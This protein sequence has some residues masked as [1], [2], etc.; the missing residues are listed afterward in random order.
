M[1]R[2][3]T[4]PFAKF[5]G[6]ANDFVVVL[7]RDVPQ[8]HGELARAI[9][10]R[11]T[12]VGADGLLVLTPPKGRKTP[13]RL[14][15]FNVDGSEAEMSG[16]GIRC[17]GAYL[18]EH[19]MAQSPVRLKTVAGR[20]TLRLVESGEGKWS[21]RVA[22]GRPILTPRRIPFQGA[23]GRGPIVG[24]PLSTHRGRIPVT[25]TSIGN[26]HCSLFVGDF[27]GIDWAR[28][29]REI[30]NDPLFPRRTN[31]EFVKV[32][33]P[34]EI[35]VRFWERGVGMTMSSG[36]GS[37]AAVVASIL[38]RRTA[39]KVRVRTLG[40]TL[41]IAWPTAGEIT[42]TGPVERIAAGTFYYRTPL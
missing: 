31:V 11:N 40:G 41:D 38:N 34:R 5:H 24:F 28:L 18:I 36:T 33:S 7:S 15:F 6:L 10:A 25:V 4:I 22:M 17:A 9:C 29:G 42:L 2:I 20:K 21:F 1:A 23:K 32:L 12:G 27:G 37:C 14:R 26:P 8:P 13:A 30:E 19:G 16:N 35:E 39:R 3:V